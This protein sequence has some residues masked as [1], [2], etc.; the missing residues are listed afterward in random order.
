[1]IVDRMT[2]LL[3]MWQVYAAIALTEICFPLFMWR[4]YLKNKPFGERIMFCV[5]TQTAYL[6]NVV[7]LLGVLKICNRWTLL[8]SLIA[9]Y[10]CVRWTFSDKQQVSHLKRLYRQ[11]RRYLHGDITLQ[12]I[13]RKMIRFRNLHHGQHLS[14]KLRNIFSQHWAVIL[15]GTV[16]FLYNAFFLCHN[17][18]IYHSYQFSDIPVHTSWVYAL[19]NGTLFVDGIYPFAMHALIYVIRVLF[20]ISL[21]EIMLYYGSFH[22]LLMF[23]TLYQ[24]SKKIFHSKWSSLLALLCFSLL[25]NQGRYAASLPQECGVFAMFTMGYYLIDYL[26]KPRKVHYV[27]GD[28]RIRRFFRINQYWSREYLDFDFFMILLSVAQIISF[29][30]YTAIAAIML[31]IAIVLSH[32]ITFFK[33][34]Y[35]IPIVTSA[36]LGAILAILP[37][38]AALSVGIPF[39]GSMGWALSVIQ[40][41]EWQGTGYGYVI[42]D[43]TGNET[44]LQVISNSEDE[45]K[46]DSPLHDATLSTAEKLKFVFEYMLAYNQGY[47]FGE[48]TTLPLLI[49]TLLTSIAAFLFLFFKRLRPYGQN[50]IAV[51]SYVFVLVVMGISSGI[52][53]P[54]I[55]EPTR[56]NVFA[57]PV[58]VLIFAIPLDIFLLIFYKG[59][60]SIYRLFSSLFSIAVCA[61]ACCWIIFSGA[62]HHYFDVNLAYFNEPDY[63]MRQIQKDFPDFQY[64][65]VS[66]TDE[67]YVAVEKGFHTELSEVVAMI[68]GNYPNF[69]FPTKYIF[70]FIEKYTLQDY[71]HGRD[72]VSLEYANLPFLY[73]A[74]TQDYY[75][76][77]NILESKAY[78]WAK[79]YAQLY[80]NN[81][82]V[83]YEDDI[84]IAYVL[85]QDVESPLSLLL[86]NDTTLGGSSNEDT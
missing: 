73:Q 65:I 60:S 18:N 81:M 23:F 24:F 48:K 47:M 39:H 62:V 42:S 34:Q 72:Y 52:G 79:K 29:H 5:I 3:T 64:T 7:I 76:Q 80:P 14:A 41:T 66:P 28:S 54:V 55:L 63:I 50:Y 84:Y 26:N 33:K 44:E 82:T 9:E 56:A 53:L 51:V 1:M 78:Y 10:L 83:Y 37:F 12:A 16:I 86:P 31:A 25:L 67:Y 19:E 27:Q 36:V 38:I 20:G 68:D 85:T 77:R 69:T 2:Y 35:F 32:F 15:F 49:C 75:Y 21:R 8:F 4:D 11:L 58:L 46:E 59:N 61:G 30:F 45:E 17:V 43:G 74:S 13:R 71:F 70:F 40:G 6:V 57:E 22:S